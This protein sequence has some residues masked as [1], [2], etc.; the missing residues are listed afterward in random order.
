MIEQTLTKPVTCK[1]CGSYA[2]VKFG[3]Y[4]ENQRYWCKD[5]NRKF[6]ADESA[7]HG[8]VPS[9]Y[10]GQAVAEFYNGDIIL[11]IMENLNQ[12][13]GY[14]PSKSI[15]WKW[16]NKYTDLAVKRFKD[17]KPNVGT[18]WLVDETV[19]VL[20][21]RY[22]V[23]VYN[24]TDLKTKYLLASHVAIS[25]TTKDAEAVM[26]QAQKR[27]G[28]TPTKVLTNTNRSF[29]GEIEL[30]YGCDAE[31]VQTHP[32]AGLDEESTERVKRYHGTI[33]GRVKVMCTFRNIETLIRFNDGWLVHY[34]FFKPQQ[35]L[36]GKTPAEESGIKY[37]V[38]NWA[39]IV[40]VPAAK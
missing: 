17:E 5:C 11:D 32:F 23:W 36:N 25:R 39:D 37:D 1:N 2:V 10:A 16:F 7:F 9:N 29:E 22:K 18:V 26:R 33:K 38:K 27:A 3:T 40:R 12:Q 19:L 15:I 21:H 24:V 14:K 6:K 35:S 31:H 13:Y 20:H 8:K 28:K 34:N 4:K 30:L